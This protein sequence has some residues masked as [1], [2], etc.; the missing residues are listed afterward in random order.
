MEAIIPAIEK[1]EQKNPYAN[2]SK[3]F[4]TDDGEIPFLKDIWGFFS[5]KGV[6]TVFVS[7]NPMN[8]FRLDLEICEN[9][10][11]PIRIFTNSDTIEEKWAVVARTLKGRKIDDADKDK[12]WL[13]GIQ[14]KWILPKNLVVKRTS[15]DWSSMFSEIK[16][17]PE[18]RVDLLKIEAYNEEERMLLYSMLDNGF[19]PGILLVKYT[20]DP[21]ANVPAMLT[22]GHLQMAG[23]R[24]LSTNN[25]WFLYV[26]TDICYYDSC[27]WRDY[28]NHNPLVR[29]I[30]ELFDVK[31]KQ[32]KALEEKAVEEKAVEEKKEDTSPAELVVENV[33]GK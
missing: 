16:Q 10:G 33:E 24:L 6:K 23:Y 13:E 15:M 20:V 29:Y 12:P 31:Q 25:N 3:L 11:C 22:A 1:M 19:R 28:S 7:V 32:Q 30:V 17:S 27:S 2:F 18:G 26:F 5:M 21:D 9:L 14:K 4:S 8:S